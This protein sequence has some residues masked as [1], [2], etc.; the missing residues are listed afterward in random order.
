MSVENVLLQ[1]PDALPL[2][3]AKPEARAQGMAVHARFLPQLPGS[4]WDYRYDKMEETLRRDPDMP[5][6]DAVKTVIIRDNVFEC[7][8]GWDI[9]LDDGS[10]NYLITGNL[11][12]RP[13]RSISKTEGAFA[14]RRRSVT[15]QSCT[16]S[17]SM[18]RRWRRRGFRERDVILEVDGQEAGSPERWAELSCAEPHGRLLFHGRPLNLL[19]YLK[20]FKFPWNALL[21]FV[22]SHLFPRQ[23]TG[24]WQ[25]QV[26]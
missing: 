15:P 7:A 10:S 16:F 21:P 4:H 8:N 22:L 13:S 23:G 3:A 20:R 11:C 26:L 17:C 1:N 18:P 5:L 12:L 14:F 24:L 9:D 6:L 2:A 19:K 25:F